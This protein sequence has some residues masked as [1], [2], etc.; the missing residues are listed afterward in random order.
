[1]HEVARTADEIPQRQHNEDRMRRA[2][3][4]HERSEEAT[5]DGERFIF[6]WIAFNAAYGSDASDSV[7]LT[8]R[9]QFTE[10]LARV[11]ERDAGNEIEGIIWD[12]FSG[13]IRI[14]PE[15]QYVFVPFWKWVQGEAEGDDWQERFERETASVRRK[16]SRRDV[17]GVLR[18]VLTGSTRCGTR[19]ST[20]ER[21]FPKGGARLRCTTAAGSWL[22]S[23]RRCSQ[24]CGPILIA[25]PIRR[26]GERSPIP[27]STSSAGSTRRRHAASLADETPP[28][29]PAPAGLDAHW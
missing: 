2:K 23:F 13:P 29:R 11:L 14:L 7:S 12:T 27:A 4:W 17:H 1:M 8:Q 26:S 21:P 25:T 9:R 15:N 28:S 22:P 19:S 6:L 20:A 5:S 16:L 18:I 10:F 3:S 24:S